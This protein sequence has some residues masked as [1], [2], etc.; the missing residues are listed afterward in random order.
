[1]KTVANNGKVQPPSGDTGGQCPLPKM[2]KSAPSG[3]SPMPE[4][5]PALLLG[6]GRSLKK[7]DISAKNLSISR[8]STA[9]D[10]GA[11]RK[12]FGKNFGNVSTLP[13]AIAVYGNFNANDRGGRRG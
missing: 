3:R 2:G 5:P 8:V 9:G 4:G 13:V 1:V 12:D 10:T 11:F 7:M 6:I